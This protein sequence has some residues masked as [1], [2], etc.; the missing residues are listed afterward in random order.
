MEKKGQII[1]A[2][3][4]FLHVQDQFDIEPSIS[5]IRKSL[6]YDA[7]LRFGKVKKL[8][9]TANSLRNIGL[10]QQFAIKTI[11]LLK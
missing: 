4:V 1:S 2:Q 9:N 7:H 3:K 5:M 6:R 8:P 11:E 10:R